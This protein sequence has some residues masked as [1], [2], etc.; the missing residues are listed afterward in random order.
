MPACRLPPNI[1]G[2]TAVGA[3]TCYLGCSVDACILCRA[4]CK[5]TQTHKH[6]NK[7]CSIGA[8]SMESLYCFGGGSKSNHASYSAME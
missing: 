1:A 2:N 3:S 7:L 8:G 4:K 5:N 6:T